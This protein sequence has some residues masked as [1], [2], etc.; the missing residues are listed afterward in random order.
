MSL[1]RKHHHI[2]RSG[3]VKR[4]GD[5]L[6]AAFNDGKGRRAARH[7]AE[8]LVQNRVGILRA[9]VI[10]G[11]DHLVREPRG[12]APHLGALRAVAVAAAAEHHEHAR[13]GKAA[14]RRE[15]VGKPVWRVG[16]VDEH[17]VVRLRRH[18][19]RPSPHA[20]AERKRA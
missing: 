7:A 2:A 10:R 13:V 17:G 11:E 1:A 16:V 9:R 3:V 6:A 15:D 8:D 12:D 20:S 4:A 19:L 14:H 5:G 18:D